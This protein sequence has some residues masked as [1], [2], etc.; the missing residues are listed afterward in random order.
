MATR[1]APEFD[2]TTLGVR[3]SA[4]GQPAGT[5]KVA[6]GVQEYIEALPR[7][8]FS[9]TLEAE[10]AEHEAF[11]KE[12]LSGD[13]GDVDGGSASEGE[14][15]PVMHLDELLAPDEYPIKD[16]PLLSKHTN[17]AEV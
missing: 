2:G 12:P 4:V 9:E 3:L 8:D 11:L 1:V 14:V 17:L 5:T 13:E 7:Y 15:E 6:D 10:M 16:D